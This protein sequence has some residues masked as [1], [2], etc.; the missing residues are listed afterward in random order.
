LHDFEGRMEEGILADEQIEKEQ[1]VETLIKAMEQLTTENRELLILCRYQDLK[2][3][4]IARI[5]NISE[6][7]VKVRV[8]RAMNELKSIFLK[9]EN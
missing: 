3:Q 1:A 8:H 4:E 5:L 7:A 9:I 2:H 6:G